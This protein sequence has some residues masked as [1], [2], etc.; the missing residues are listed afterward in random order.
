MMKC[1][2][3]R[4]LVLPYLDSELDAKTS[5]E[6]QL[7]LQA[8]AECA[9]L[10][11]REEEFSERLFSVLRTGQTTPAIWEKVESRLRPRHCAAWF[12]RHWKILSGSIA[13]LIMALATAWFVVSPAMPSLDLA[14]AVAK[15]HTEFLEGKKAPEFKGALPEAIAKKLGEHL[16]RAA[17]D[18]LPVG[19]RFHA[20][21]ARLCDL[22]GVPAAWT[23]GHCGQVPVSLIVFKKSELNHFP[24]AQARLASGER[25]VCTRSGRFQFAVRFVDGH[26]V[27][28]MAEASKETLEALLESIHVRADRFERSSA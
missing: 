19:S 4:N 18:V 20:D 13:T 7:H 2:E 5:Q 28:A 26:V 15:D 3:I 24:E 11:E 27:C 16:D 22:D 21:G 14:Q 25:I 23:V 6:I 12:L 9:Q 17:F 10:F 1:N 8:C